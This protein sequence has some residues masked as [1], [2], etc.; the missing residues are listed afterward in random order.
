MSGAD[1]RAG[2]HVKSIVEKVPLERRDHVEQ[3]GRCYPCRRDRSHGAPLSCREFERCAVAEC[4]ISAGHTLAR[5]VT[6]ARLTL[7][8]LPANDLRSCV[9]VPV[10]SDER[11]GVGWWL[12]SRGHRARNS[13]GD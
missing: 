9:T 12:R 8:Y 10:V 4:T 5:G 7:E 11:G 3:R 6:V 2:S 1:G 13:S